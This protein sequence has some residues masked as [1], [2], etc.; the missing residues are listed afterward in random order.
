MVIIIILG[1]FGFSRQT[2]LLWNE[3]QLHG[4]LNHDALFKTRMD[5]DR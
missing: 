3:S 5:Y 4:F 2:V 1:G